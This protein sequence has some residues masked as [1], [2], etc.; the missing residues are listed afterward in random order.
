MGCVNFFKRHKTD[1]S[2]KTEF[3][4]EI[5]VIPRCEPVSKTRFLAFS[6]WSQN[7][8]YED[9]RRIFTPFVFYPLPG[10]QSSTTGANTPIVSAVV[11][12]S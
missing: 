7:V 1:S 8:K 10:I 9:A 11:H 5:A 4:A 3:F 12:I 6:Q 2:E